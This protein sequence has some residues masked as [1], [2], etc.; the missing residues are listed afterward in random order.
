L[1]GQTGAAARLIERG[2]LDWFVG[3]DLRAEIVAAAREAMARVR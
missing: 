3:K 2:D 1:Q